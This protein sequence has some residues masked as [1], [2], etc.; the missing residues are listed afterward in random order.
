MSITIAWNGGEKAV[1]VQP[2]MKVL[3]AI[4]AIFTLGVVCVGL[5]ALALVGGAAYLVVTLAMLAVH[6]LSAAI[7]SSLFSFS[8]SLLLAAFLGVVLVAQSLRILGVQ[9]KSAGVA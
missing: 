9:K 5:A 6:A 4:A 3:V 8:L 1:M 7:Y 2:S